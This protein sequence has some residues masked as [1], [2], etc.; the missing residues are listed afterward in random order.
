MKTRTKDV[1]EADVVT[2]YQSNSTRC[3]GNRSR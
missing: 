3:R 2:F 1:G